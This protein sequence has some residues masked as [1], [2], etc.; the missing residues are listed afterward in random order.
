VTELRMLIGP[1]FSWESQ[2]AQYAEKGEPGVALETH[3]VDLLTGDEVFPPQP[4]GLW[5]ESDDSITKVHC[6][7]HR[8]ANGR[9]LG[10]LN[11]YDGKHYLEGADAI[12]VWVRPD[13]QRLGI[14][15]Q[16]VKEA[17]RRWPE[18]TPEKQ[19]YTEAGLALLNR[20]LA[21]DDTTTPQ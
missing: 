9:L 12:N 11:H 16:L 5:A 13:V 20:V 19:R 2:A 17:V 4:R 8:D 18:I 3:Y 1:M 10:I 7:L 14:G 15:S 21:E 6:L